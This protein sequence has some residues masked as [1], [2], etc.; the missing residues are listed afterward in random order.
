M[1]KRDGLIM[2]KINYSACGGG[3]GRAA[4]LLLPLPPPSPPPVPP[5]MPMSRLWCGIVCRSQ[6]ATHKLIIGGLLIFDYL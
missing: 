3:G 5:M 4:A 2:L 6:F 1:N